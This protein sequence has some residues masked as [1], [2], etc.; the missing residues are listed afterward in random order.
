MASYT[1]ISYADRRFKSSQKRL[2][3]SARKYKFFDEIFEYSRSSISIRFFVKNRD[4]IFNKK[5]G[6][7]WVWKPYIIYNALKKINFGDYLMYCDSGAEFINSPSHLFKCFD[8]VS[9]DVILFDA[10]G[11]MENKYT[12]PEVAQYFEVSSDIMNTRQRAGGYQLFRK[13]DFSVKFV[14]TWLKYCENKN[15]LVGSKLYAYHRHDQSLLSLLSK[16]A[17]IPSFRDPSQYGNDF[18]R[19]Y[20]LSDYPQIFNLHRTKNKSVWSRSRIKII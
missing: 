6:G 8:V 16:R 4:V 18:F 15:L 1:L 17:K 13:S 7:Y 10:G 14:E 11:T 20:P 9:S 2:S 12:D 5:G 19:D 3:E